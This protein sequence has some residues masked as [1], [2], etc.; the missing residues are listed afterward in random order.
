MDRRWVL[1]FTITTNDDLLVV[2]E[3]S[4]LPLPQKTMSNAVSRT[5]TTGSNAGR[6]WRTLTSTAGALSGVQLLED[7]V[8]RPFSGTAMA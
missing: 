6:V 3:T 7:Q 4:A 5:P 1:V 8:L 2:T